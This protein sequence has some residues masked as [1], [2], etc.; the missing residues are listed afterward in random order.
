MLTKE[1]CPNPT[2]FTTGWLH[3]ELGQIRQGDLIRPFTWFTLAL[4]VFPTGIWLYGTEPLGLAW[5]L[6]GTIIWVVLLTALSVP[7]QWVSCASTAR[8][9]ARS[10]LLEDDRGAAGA[11]LHTRRGG[12]WRLGWVWAQPV[13]AGLG[14]KLMGQVITDCGDEA[15]HLVAVNQAA[16]RFYLRY[17]FTRHGRRGFAGYPMTRPANGETPGKSRLE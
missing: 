1:G 10:W 9:A 2:R 8:R 17:G 11:L 15:L 12:G 5:Q 16:A 14:N 3:A 4:V 13:G 7:A 6:G